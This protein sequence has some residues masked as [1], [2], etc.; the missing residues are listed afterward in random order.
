[1]QKNCKMIVVACNTVSSLAMEYLQSHFPLPIIGVIQPGVDFAIQ[2]TK[3]NKIGVIGTQATIQ[4]NAYVKA[5]HSIMPDIKV[6]SKACPLFVPL[7]EEG[8]VDGDIPS[9]IADFYL[10][11]I[12]SSDIDTVILGCTHYPL[13]KKV[14]GAVLGSGITLIDSGNAIAKAVTF[15]LDKHDLI[16]TIKKGSTQCFVTD[17]PKY[18]DVV[19][20]KLLQ[21][22]ITPVSYTH[23]TLPTKA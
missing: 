4:S 11:D 1:M 16:S 8:I 17:D 21:T 12:Q 6:I 9:A 5:L 19:A 15:E 13:L 23:L 2:I 14:I 18:F 22:T 10:K 20:S 7:A 3:N